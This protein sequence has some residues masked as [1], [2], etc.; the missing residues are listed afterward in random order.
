M[1]DEARLRRA[2]RTVLSA[3]MVDRVIAMAKVDDRA[4][5]AELRARRAER[6]IEIDDVA[7]RKAARALRRIGR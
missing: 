7:S 1:I 4:E 2:L 5:R 3:S 6:G